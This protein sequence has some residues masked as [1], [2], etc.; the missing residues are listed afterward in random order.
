MVVGGFSLPCVTLISGQEAYDSKGIVKSVRFR[1]K[2]EVIV[3][4]E[5]RLQNYIFGLNSPVGGRRLLANIEYKGWTVPS[6]FKCENLN[7]R[8][9]SLWFFLHII[10]WRRARHSQTCQLSLLVALKQMAQQKFFFFYW[11]VCVWH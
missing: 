6:G 1:V 4:T 10:V 9:M 7:I 11:Q 5:W 8:L 2:A 3:R